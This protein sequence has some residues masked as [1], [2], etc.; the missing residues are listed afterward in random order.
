MAS[1]WQENIDFWKKVRSGL[2]EGARAGAEAMARYLAERAANDTLQ[3]SSHAPGQYYDAPKGAPPAS[4]SGHLAASMYWTRGQ[5]G[6]KAAADVGNRARHAKLMEYGDCDIVPTR[7]KVMHWT[8]S[9]G[10]W[11]HA[12]LPAEE[13]PFMGPTVEESSDDGSLTDAAMDAFREYDP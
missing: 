1:P 2:P 12:R 5:G 6:L 7:M 11:Y 9:G 10:S 13:H 8:D 4:A 3:R